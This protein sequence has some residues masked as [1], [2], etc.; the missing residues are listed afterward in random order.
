MSFIAQC[1]IIIKVIHNL[2]SSF[3]ISRLH[4]MVAPLNNG[5]FFRLLLGH[6]KFFLFTKKGSIIKLN[7]LYTLNVLNSYSGQFYIVQHTYF[8]LY[9]LRLCDCIMAFVDCNVRRGM[10]SPLQ[11]YTSTALQWL[12]ELPFFDDEEDESGWV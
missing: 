11:I 3:T 6:T 1:S 7:V 12:K 4:V 5:I 10:C 2:V 9:R 8:L